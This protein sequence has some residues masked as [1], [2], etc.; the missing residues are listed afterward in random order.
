[1]AHLVQDVMAVVG[2]SDGVSASKAIDSSHVLDGFL[3][4]RKAQFS[5]GPAN[6]F[7][8]FLTR[9]YGRD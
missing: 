3:A 7:K 8:G 6:N 2:G 5:R 9:F 1:M 4:D